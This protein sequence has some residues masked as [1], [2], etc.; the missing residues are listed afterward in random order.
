MAIG[1]FAELQTAIANWLDRDDL[2]ARIPEFIALSE[3]RINRALNVRQMETVK[4]LSL[5]NGTKRYALP[6]DYLGMR[7]FKYNTSLIKE[8]TLNGT[9][10]D[11]VD[12]IVLTSATGFTATGTVKIGDEQ[13]TYSGISTNTLTGCTRAA[14]STTA[15]AHSSGVQVIQIYTDWTVGTISGV[16]SIIYPLQFISPEILSST[17]AGSNSGLPAYYSMVAGFILLGPVPASVYTAE[18]VYYARIP[19]LSDTAT[20]NWCLTQNPDLFIYGA[21]ME[22]EPYLMN[23]ARINTWA[24][25]FFKALEDINAR[26]SMDRFSGSELVV[27]NTMG[28]P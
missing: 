24:T 23:D 13:I 20:T 16:Q 2:T 27:R 19:A 1:T 26:D 7:G 14:N 5:I 28:T 17:W 4:L 6:D 3:A 18:I 11:S 9:I 10:N 25:A 22:C 12:A 8:T 21:L 15:A